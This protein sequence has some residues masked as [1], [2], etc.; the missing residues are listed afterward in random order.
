MRPINSSGKWLI[1]ILLFVASGTAQAQHSMHRNSTPLIKPGN[2]IFGTIQ[3]VVQKLEADP[4]TDW[5]RVNLEALR[6][7][8]LDMKAFTEDVAVLSKRPVAN[9]VEIQVRPETERA[10]E[11]LKKLFSMHPAMIKE[12]KGWDMEVNHERNK[13]IITCTTQNKA[14]ID[15]MRALGYIGLLTEGAHHQLHHWMIATG[16]MKMK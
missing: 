8:L 9:G 12:E 3:E 10:V 2:D 15:K 14:E 16:L 1:A 6:Q 4:N 7:H 5:S 11:A 13:W